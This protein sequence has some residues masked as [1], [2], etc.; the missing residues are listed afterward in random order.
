ML[1]ALPS[2][3]EFLM[4]LGQGK[5]ALHWPSSVNWGTLAGTSLK[6]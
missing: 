5:A 1:M 6:G 2:D 3:P 4:E